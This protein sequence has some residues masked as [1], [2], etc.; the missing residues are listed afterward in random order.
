MRL[1]HRRPTRKE[2]DMTP[3]IDVA[4]Q[5]IIFFM[6]VSQ[7]SQ[8]NLEQLQLPRQIG[9]EDEKPQPIVVNVT[10]NGDFRISGDTLP[11]EQVA[12]RLREEI[13]R[14]DNDPNRV[15]VV[16]RADERGESRG[17]N[18]IVR[19]LNQ[20]QITRMRIAVQSQP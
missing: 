1:A 4:F 16:V 5:L 11:F 2:M 13:G 6:T 7:M 18:S 20:L 10:E 8:A 3:M 14:A 12:G 15:T 17:V 19:M 9:E